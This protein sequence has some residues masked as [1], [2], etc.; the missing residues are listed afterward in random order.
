VKSS[1]APSFGEGRAIDFFDV[2]PADFRAPRATPAGR[3]HAGDRLRM[4]CKNRFDIAAPAISYEAGERQS[5]GLALR[6]GAKA[7]T[8]HQ[9]AD[10]DTHD[11]L[12]DW[13]GHASYR[14]KRP[15]LASTD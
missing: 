1:C 10:P 7:D 13:H 9:A 11:T 12:F 3:T 8:L 14:K 6:P 5:H 2:D 15:A 4:P